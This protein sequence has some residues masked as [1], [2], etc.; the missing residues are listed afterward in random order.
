MDVIHLLL[1]FYFNFRGTHLGFGSDLKVVF[2]EFGN[3]RRESRFPDDRGGV[4]PIDPNGNVCNL[5]FWFLKFWG[6]LI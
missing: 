4:F 3:C 6:F 1:G 2:A 5:E